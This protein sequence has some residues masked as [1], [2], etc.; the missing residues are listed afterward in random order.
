MASEIGQKNVKT[1]YLVVAYHLSP[2]A[3]VLSYF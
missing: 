2:S 1:P 3:K